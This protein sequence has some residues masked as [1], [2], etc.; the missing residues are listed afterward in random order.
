MEKVL[1]AMQQ[2]FPVLTSLELCGDK[3]PV[4]SASFLGGS[5]PSLESLCLR[6]VPFPELPK[7]LLTATRL[8]NLQRFNSWIFLIPDTFHQKRWPLLSPS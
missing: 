1:A 3:A 7:L 8:V 2:P 4:V 5:A 6:H